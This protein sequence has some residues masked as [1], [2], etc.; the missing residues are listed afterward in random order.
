VPARGLA[1]DTRMLA[2]SLR[3]QAR[4]EE[5]LD[6][7]DGQLE[8]FEHVYELAAQ[9]LGEFRASRKEQH[10]EWAIIALLAAEVVMFLLD[11]L[12]VRVT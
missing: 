5:R 2:E 1:D 7:V 12:G 9:R 11:L 8:V 3:A 4:V 6:T 10:L